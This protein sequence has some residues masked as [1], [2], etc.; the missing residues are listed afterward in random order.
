[1]VLKLG[2]YSTL[3][4]VKFCVRSSFRLALAG[5]RQLKFPFLLGV[6]FL[7]RLVR[8]ANWKIHLILNSNKNNKLKHWHRK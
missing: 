4:F 5:D 8:I 7:N 2:V 3:Q 1:M 6:Q